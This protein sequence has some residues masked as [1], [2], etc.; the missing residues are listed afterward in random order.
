MEL[1]KCPSCG[2]SVLAIAKVCKHCSYSFEAQ[3]TVHQKESNEVYKN[4]AQEPTK[5]SPIE[6]TIENQQAGSPYDFSNKGMFK[7][8]FSFKGRIRRLEYFLSG[9]IYAVWYGI[10]RALQPSYWKEPSGFYWFWLMLI[11]P[12][13]YFLLA[14]GAKRCHDRDNSGWYQ[15]IPFYGL[16][17]LFADGDEGNNSYGDSPKS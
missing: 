13:C 1:K 9:L 16:W 12:L 6:Q 4:I 11:F 8:P 7:R 5:Q 17:M 2:K 15:I 14:Q 10:L 3:G